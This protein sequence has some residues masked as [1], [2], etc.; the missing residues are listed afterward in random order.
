MDVS[1]AWAAMG[2]GAD[3]RLAAKARETYK[4]RAYK[5]SMARVKARHESGE[6]LAQEGWLDDRFVPLG[7]EVGGAWCPPVAPALRTH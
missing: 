1:M 4:Q 3:C 5:A 6:E 7:F 2:I